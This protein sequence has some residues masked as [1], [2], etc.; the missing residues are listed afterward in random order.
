[1]R[2]PKGIILAAGISVAAASLAGS[3]SAAVIIKSFV[4]SPFSGLNTTGS[5]PP[6]LLLAGNTYDFTFDLVAPIVG[7]SSTQAEA[8]LIARSGS[9]PELIQY[10]LYEG[11]PTTADPENGT[12]LV[13]SAVGF[14]PTLFGTLGVGDYYLNIVPSEIAASGE[15]ASG[16]FITTGVPEPASWGLMLLGV[17]MIG[18][19]MRIGRRNAALTIA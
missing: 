3:A 7:P 4:G 13:T 17:G 11:N 19:G 5:L 6:T 15:L 12:L 16:S 14:S 10:Q 1:M 9:T 18:M 2:V 8:Q